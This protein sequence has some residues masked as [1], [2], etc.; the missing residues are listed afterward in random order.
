[1]NRDNLMLILLF[2]FIMILSFINNII[3]LFGY[4]LSITIFYLIMRGRVGTLISAMLRVL[5]FLVVLSFAFYISSLLSK[6]HPYRY[7]VILNLRVFDMV[8]SLMFFREFANPLRAL[9]FSSTLTYIFILSYS[10]IKTF[11]ELYY[12]FSL[13]MRSRMVLDTSYKDRILFLRK[14]AGYFFKKAIAR[15]EDTAMAMKA[16]GFFLYD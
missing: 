9:S 13:V 15:A 8:L 2:L 1:M 5:P 16:R 7:L 6:G 11:T 12:D 10:Q 14:M 4:F 3:F